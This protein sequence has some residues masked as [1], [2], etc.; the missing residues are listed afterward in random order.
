MDEN[1]EYSFHTFR[2]C[3][4]RPIKAVIRIIYHSTTP[5]EIETALS[6]LGFSVVSV[7]NFINKTKNWSL[8]L[9]AIELEDNEFSRNIFV[10]LNLHNFKIIVEKRRLRKARGHPQCKWCQTYRH[11][12]KYCCHHLCCVNVA[13]IISLRSVSRRAIFRQNAPYALVITQ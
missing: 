2:P 9:F 10:V 1:K 12:L 4:L 7:S 11:T 6:V 5:K 13:R 3:H 8:S